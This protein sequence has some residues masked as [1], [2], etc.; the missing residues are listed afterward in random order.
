MI[1]HAFDPAL[2]PFTIAL[3]VMAMIA[4]LEIAG[5]L[6][7]A[8]PSSL[9]D[10]MLPDLDA[11]ADAPGLHVETP[12]HGETDG[13]HGAGPLSQLLS[14]LCVGRVPLLVLIVAFLT[15]FGAVGLILQGFMHGVFGFFAP[16]IV[17]VFP[18]FFAALPLTRALGLTLGKIMPKEESDAVSEETFIGKVATII[19]GTAKRGF[20]AEAKLKDLSGKTHYILVEPDGE[21]EEFT[22]GAEVI[23]VQKSGAVCRVIANEHP[24]LGGNRQ[25]AVGSRE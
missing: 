6:I 25:S 13:A 4:A 16:S 11:D 17:M 7:G 23:V 22:Q 8:Q 20:P 18:A 14:W 2:A 21:G 19:R 15:A 3:L 9:V 1:A 5:T 24:S 12:S 10:S